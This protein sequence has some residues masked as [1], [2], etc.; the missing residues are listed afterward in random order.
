MVILRWV[1]L[2]AAIALA[3]PHPHDDS[4]DDLVTVTMKPP[5]SR[6]VKVT[7]TSHGCVESY[8]GVPFAEPREYL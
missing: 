8:L 1:T 2:F 5:G 6:P 4:H 3:R 7:G